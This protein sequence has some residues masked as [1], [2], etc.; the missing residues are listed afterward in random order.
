V[1]KGGT[2]ANRVGPKEARKH[3]WR[4]KTR[5]MTMIFFP[6]KDRDLLLRTPK[7]KRG[8]ERVAKEKE[9]VSFLEEKKGRRKKCSQLGN[10][11]EAWG[12]MEDE[13]RGKREKEKGTSRKEKKKSLL[14]ICQGKK[15]EKSIRKS[16]SLRNC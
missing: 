3:N 14:T 10:E 2:N 16:N 4:G 8:G 7:R 12:Q 11:I 15:K 5:K 6:Q 1:R 9:K 13:K